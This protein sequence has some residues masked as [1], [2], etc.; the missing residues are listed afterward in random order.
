MYMVSPGEQHRT[1]ESTYDVGTTHAVGTA[2]YIPEGLTCVFSKELRAGLELV[3]M[4]WL[5]P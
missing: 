1:R 4:L 3:S 5:E 2:D